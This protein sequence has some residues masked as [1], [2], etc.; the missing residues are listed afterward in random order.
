[1]FHGRNQ[2]LWGPDAREF[3]P[4]RWFEVSEQVQSPVGVY[5]NLYGYPWNYDRVGRV[6]TFHPALR[7]PEV[8]GAASGGD[9]RASTT[10]R[11]THFHRYRVH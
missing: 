8:S 3:R 5:G 7:S 2:G 4:E 11:V 10:F 6:L 1:M 9:S